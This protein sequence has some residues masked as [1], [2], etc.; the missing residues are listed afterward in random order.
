MR[1]FYDDSNNLLCIYYEINFKEDDPKVNF[2]TDSN[3]PLQVAQMS[4][5]FNEIIQPHIHNLIERNLQ[6]TSEILILSSGSMR[7]DLFDSAKDYV[8]SFIARSNSIV[9]LFFG[10]HGFEILEDV[11]M[12]EIKQGP[13]SEK[14]KNRFDYPSN[15]NLR[16]T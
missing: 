15:L 2:V 9:M 16:I 8:S 6:V 1:K 13:Y 11:K 4:R 3:L 12:I 10:G 7:V 14:D 5:P